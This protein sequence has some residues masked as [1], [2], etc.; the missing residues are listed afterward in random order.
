MVLAERVYAGGGRRLSECTRNT[1]PQVKRKE[2]Y[3]KHE[4][5]EELTAEETQ[6]LQGVP[7]TVSNETESIDHP[8]DLLTRIITLRMQRHTRT[9]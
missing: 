7:S 2:A 8:V 5:G 4:A 1:T 3:E 9:L 6:L